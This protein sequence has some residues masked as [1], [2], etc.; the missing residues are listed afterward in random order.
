[1]R[2]TDAP[3]L[4][5]ALQEL[6]EQDP[7]ITVRQD[8]TRRITVRLYGEVQKEVLQETLTDQH[9]IAVEFS[10]TQTVCVERPVGTGESVWEIG[11]GH[12]P[13]CATLG[14]RVSPGVPG[15]GLTFGL[16]VELG[17]LPLAFHKA[18]EETVEAALARGLSG[19]EVVDVAVTVTRTGYSSPVTVAGDFRG[20]TPLVLRKA[21][22]QA[23]TEVLEP[24]S[25]F[26]L[27]L[28]ADAV[29]ATLSRLVELGALVTESAI[30]GDRAELGGTLPT[31]RVH[32]FDQQLPA[33]SHGEGLLT[34]RPSGYQP[35]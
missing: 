35:I 9:G 12:N 8:E 26:E 31:A 4:F 34:T 20:V 5:A 14:L 15:S 30:C 10:G 16:E 7:L 18:I 3:A 29:S 6:A 33:L 25:G 13:F 11:D 17:S 28:P 21:L 2:T 19:W 22:R 27:E 32:G 24:V 1:M 23:G